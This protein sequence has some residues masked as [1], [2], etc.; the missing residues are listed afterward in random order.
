[1]TAAPLSALPAPD[2]PTHALCVPRR[3]L[4]AAEVASRRESERSGKLQPGMS[5]EEYLKMMQLDSPPGEDGQRKVSGGPN[6]GF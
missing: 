4:Y 3:Q 2:P 1:M 5:K 6:L